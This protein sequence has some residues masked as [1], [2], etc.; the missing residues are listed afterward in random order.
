MPVRCTMDVFIVKN[1]E[2][3]SNN[4]TLQEFLSTVWQTV[5]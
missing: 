3:K 2:I 5:I 1:V 4:A